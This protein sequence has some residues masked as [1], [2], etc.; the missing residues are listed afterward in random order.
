[1]WSLA[2]APPSTLELPTSRRLIVVLDAARH[3][4]VL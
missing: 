4:S 1:V 3:R 2:V